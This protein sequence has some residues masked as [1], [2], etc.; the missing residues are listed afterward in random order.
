VG[1][2]P[3]KVDFLSPKEDLLPPP[4]AVLRPLR[5]AGL[6]VFIAIMVKGVS[7]DWL[8]EG[9]K[10][11]Q[12]TSEVTEKGLVGWDNEARGTEL[13]RLHRVNNRMLIPLESF[14][15]SGKYHSNKISTPNR[16]FSVTS[17]AFL[18]ENKA[19]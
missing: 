19:Y 12:R 7:L 18:G 17:S 15:V 10:A 6:K 8:G 14:R 16:P 5:E 1:L 3:P 2:N 4:L 9:W 11:V 13:G